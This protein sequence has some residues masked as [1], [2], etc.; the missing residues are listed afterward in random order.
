MGNSDLELYLSAIDEMI[1][2][3][4]VSPSS[5]LYFHAVRDKRLL[6][7]PGLCHAV[8]VVGLNMH[9]PINSKESSC[10]YIVSSRATGAVKIGRTKNGARNRL[11]G[12]RCGCPDAVVEYEFDGAGNFEKIVHKMLERYSVG[13]E[14]FAVSPE[15]AKAAI[16]SVLE[17]SGKQQ[18]DNKSF[19][20]TKEAA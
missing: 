14:W 4:V 11:K 13:G 6:N 15:F 20:S 9:K 16:E 7:Y 2:S 3:H 17:G 8:M 18:S 12:I 1:C 10:L 19:Q 5:S